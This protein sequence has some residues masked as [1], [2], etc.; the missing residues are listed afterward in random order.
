MGYDLINGRMKNERVRGIKLQLIF[1]SNTLWWTNMTIEHEPFEDVFPI[2]NGAF[3]ASY[4]RL[5]DGIWL[6][7]RGITKI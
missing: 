1:V 4:V 2:E 7:V 3:P 6:L 5:P